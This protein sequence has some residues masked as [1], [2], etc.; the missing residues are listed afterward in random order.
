MKKTKSTP[1]LFDLDKKQ[2]LGPKQ[3]KTEKNFVPK[4]CSLE[5]FWSQKNFG[6]K[7]NFGPPKNFGPKMNVGPK[8]NFGPKK[9][10]VPENL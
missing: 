8:Q 7:K 2:I 3:L 5:N 9:V 4:N 6:L 1:Y 10:L